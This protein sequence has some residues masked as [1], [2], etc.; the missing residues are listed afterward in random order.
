MS[1]VMTP[2]FCFPATLGFEGLDILPTPDGNALILDWSDTG[3][4]HDTTGVHRT[5]GRIFKI[6][7]DKARSEKSERFAKFVAGDITALAEI[8]TEGSEWESRQARLRLRELKLRGTNLQDATQI[9]RK[10]FSGNQTSKVRLRAL[11]NL[12]AI[13]AFSEQDLLTLLNAQD[14]H[15]RNWAVKLLADKWAIDTS[16][17]SRPAIGGTP[18]DIVVLHRFVALAAEEKSAAVRLSLASTL[19]RIPYSQRPALA[20]ALFSTQRMPTIIT[21]R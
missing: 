18:S 7:Y 5:S 8:L 17:G 20:Q 2:T 6:I 16:D 1:D 9:L 3:E 21:C 13:E 15:L 11:W 19:Q 14:E 4:C 12:V 10:I